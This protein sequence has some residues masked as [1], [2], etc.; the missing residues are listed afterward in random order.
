MKLFVLKHTWI[1]TLQE[2]LPFSLPDREILQ[3]ELQD[4]HILAL[5]PDPSGCQAPSEVGSIRFDW[6]AGLYD[7]YV[8]E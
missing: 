5:F 1:G 2:A 7:I 3:I 4:T 8:Q 6:R